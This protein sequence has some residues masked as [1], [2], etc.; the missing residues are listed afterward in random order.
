MRGKVR[1]ALVGRSVAVIAGSAAMGVCA[2]APPDH[3]NQ[4]NVTF[5]EA[6]VVIT[7]HVHDLGIFQ[8]A[9]GLTAADLPPASIRHGPN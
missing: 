1:L 6:P 7:D 8:I 3:A 2:A 9:T 5:R 4:I